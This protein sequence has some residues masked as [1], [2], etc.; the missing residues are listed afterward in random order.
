M[1][2]VIMWAGIAVYFL[3]LAEIIAVIVHSVL[4]FW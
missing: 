1:K 3:I 4:K 2:W